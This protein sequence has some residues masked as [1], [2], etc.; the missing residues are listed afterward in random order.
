M[1]GPMSV[2]VIPNGPLKISDAGSARYCG[3]PIA[4]EGDLYLC[5]CGESSNAPFCDG[6]HRKVGFA[7]ASEDPPDQEIRVWEG[8]TL[9]T[10]FNKTTCMH[11]FYCKPLNDLR[12]REL[13]G[14]AAAAD[15]IIKVVGTCPSGALSYEL[16]TDRQPPAAPAPEVAI[17]IVEGGEVRLQAAFEINHPLNERQSSDKATLCRCGASKNKPWCDGRHRGRKGFR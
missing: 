13:A 14:D 11:V 16:K 10:F 12:A 6:T 5:R 7:G 15:E 9:R 4:S 1:A 3:E 17:D 2:T 8:D